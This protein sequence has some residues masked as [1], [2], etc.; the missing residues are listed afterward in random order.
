MRKMTEPVDLVVRERDSQFSQELCLSLM[1]ADSETEVIGF[2]RDAGYWERED[3]WRHFGDNE[4]NWATIGNQQS[5]PEAALVEKLVNSVDARLVQ[6]CQEAGIS[7]EGDRAPSTIRKAVARFFDPHGNPESSRAGLISEWSNSYRTEVAREITLAI[8]GA[9]PSAG[10]PCFTISDRGE[11]Q[12]PRKFPDT[13]L[14]LHRSNKLR[15][16]FVQGK[17]NMGGTGALRFCG[18]E[19][20][21]LMVSRRNPRLISGTTASD[22]HWGFT[23]VRRRQE[24]GRSTVYSFLAPVGADQNPRKGNVLNF[25]A[26]ALPTLPSGNSAYARDTVWG[27][28]IKLY[29][30]QIKRTSHILLKDGLLGRLDLL[31]AEAALPIRLYECR[32]YKGHEGSFANNLMGFRVRLEDNRADNLEFDPSSSDL[33]VLGESM[34]AT[35]FA[36]K[37]GRA[38]TYRNDEGIV[39]TMNGQTHGYLSTSFFRRKKVGMSYLRDSILVVVDCSGISPRAREDMFMNSRDRL[40]DSR[41]RL[42]IEGELERLLKEHQGLR[43]L[44]ERRRREEVETKVGDDKPLEDLL[45]SMLRDSPMLSQF[46]GHGQRLRNP[47]RPPNVPPVDDPFL[48]KKYPTFFHF[49][50]REPDVSLVRECQVGRRARIVFSTNA[51]NEYFSRDIDP[52]QFNLSINTAKGL[53]DADNYVLNLDEGIANLHVQ[54]PQE[55]VAGDQVAF[56]ALTTDAAQIKP[57]LNQFKLNL[58]PK[59]PKPPGPP[60]PPRPS[61]L[62]LPKVI[63]VPEGMWQMY[64][65][66][67]DERT[68]L[69]I[70]HTGDAGVSETKE[71]SE[72]YDFFVNVDNIHLKGFLKDNATLSGVGAKLVRAQFKFGLVLLGLALIRQ[73]SYEKKMSNRNDQERGDSDRNVEDQVAEFAR[74]AAA[75]L[76]PVIRSLGELDIDD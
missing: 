8:T 44:R 9:K 75:V 47:F 45:R 71:A 12:T 55:F 32:N 66:P 37:K 34:T 27:T 5:R 11:G 41:L 68:A 36:F 17:F 4:N 52:G 70:R 54:L 42:A 19:N 60:K 64:T 22:S 20:L 56:R 39:F 67:F 23:I 13:L 53:V 24:G 33:R 62:N 46:F 14:S 59:T 1:R 74:A 26:D 51:E 76:L 3:V 6:A 40:A 50:G 61:G 63:E 65:P 15:I 2:L 48:G 10:Y 72:I 31:L 69:R 29:E 73:D 58:V 57:F 43:D 25:S 16:P 7:P 35:I 38:D 21:Q 30:Y 28:L 49:K 18:S